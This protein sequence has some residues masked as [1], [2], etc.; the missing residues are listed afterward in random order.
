RNPP[1]M[2]LGQSA[3]VAV[4]AV[5]VREQRGMDV[6]P[7]RADHAHAPGQLAGAKARIDENA[8]AI[9]LQ[10]AGVSLAPRSQHREA[11]VHTSFP[12]NDM[13]H[14]LRSAMIRYGGVHASE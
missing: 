6:G 5:C 2:E 14:S 13:R 3:L 7:G 10:Q 4:I 8:K 9:D 11:D 1:G 12:K